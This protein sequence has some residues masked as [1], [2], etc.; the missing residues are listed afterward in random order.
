MVVGVNAFTGE[1]ELEV[2]VRR[3]VPHP[4]DPEK[5]ARAEERQMDS[6]S[7]VKKSR[8]SHEVERTLN[9]LR[10]AAGDE[11]MNLIPP[12]VEAVKSYASIGEICNVLRSV[13]GEYRTY[14]Q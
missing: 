6:L 4:Y 10:E 2:S 12:T 13:F 14:R 11:E 7:A 3:S 1:N 5:R 9:Q 8:D